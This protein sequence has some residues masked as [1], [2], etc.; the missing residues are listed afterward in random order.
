MKVKTDVEL[1]ATEI[2]FAVDYLK[3]HPES[4]KALHGI[5]NELVLLTQLAEREE[6]K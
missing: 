6:S 1:L 5:A 2:G 3:D 4:L